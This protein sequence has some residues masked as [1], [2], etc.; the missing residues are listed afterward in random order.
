MPDSPLAEEDAALQLARDA[1]LHVWL[2]GHPGL[3]R[4]PDMVRVAL[5]VF[6]RDAAD[7][8]HAGLQAGREMRAPKGRAD[9]AQLARM[10]R[11]QGFLVALRREAMEGGEVVG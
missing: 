4:R 2:L 9:P 6:F 5:R 7:A 8:L 3:Q 10:L 11:G 1:G